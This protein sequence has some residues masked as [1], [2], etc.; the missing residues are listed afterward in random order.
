MDLGN[1]IGRRT[2][3]NGKQRCKRAGIT[4]IAMM[5]IV[6]SSDFRKGKRRAL[7]GNH[8][9]VHERAIN[10]SL[11]AY[12]YLGGQKMLQHSREGFPNLPGFSSRLA[13]L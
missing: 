10:E 13:A 7:D 2:G 5:Y 8:D 1:N 12:A 9:D 6:S 3:N 11:D 4:S